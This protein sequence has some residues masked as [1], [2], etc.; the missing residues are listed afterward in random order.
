MQIDS[1]ESNIEFRQSNKSRDFIEGDE[2]EE[3]QKRFIKTGTILHNI[4][5]TIRTR[6]DVGQALLQLEN[7]GILY[8]SVITKER[9]VSMIEKRLNSEKV[10]NWFSG[11]WKLYNEC[12][13]LVEKSL[14]HE[15]HEYRPDRVMTNGKETI[16][17]DFKFGKS[18]P[19]Y[20]LQVK[21]YMTLLNEMGHTNVK[22]FL[23]YVYNN[24]IE[25]VDMHQ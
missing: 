23:W 5:S 8:D 12:T 14:T 21:R 25:E 6:D 24:V 16:V 9:L 1:F 17:V 2:E 4:F 13:I 11:R 19:E 10:S 15:V 18:R 3:Q 22:G 20:L 7:D